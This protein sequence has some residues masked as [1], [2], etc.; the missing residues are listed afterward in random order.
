MFGK[1]C[2]GLFFAILVYVTLDLSLAAMPGAFVFDLADS[3]ES[4]QIRA[5]AA[6]ES[7]VLSAEARDP[8]WSLFQ[9]PLERKELLALSRSAE[10]HGNTVV[11]RRVPARD[12]SPPP[13]K[14]PH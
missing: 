6:T 7:V 13:S 1:R 14:D 3:A 2:R 11:S 8:G 10:R 5:R 4:T 12:D 9:L